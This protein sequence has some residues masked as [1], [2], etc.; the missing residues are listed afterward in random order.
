MKRCFFH[1]ATRVAIAAFFTFCAI[2]QGRAPEAAAPG[3]ALFVAN[4]AFCH[5]AGARGGSQGG[6]DLVPSPI[7]RNDVDGKQLSTFLKVGRPDK[8]MPAFH[9]TGQQVKALSAFLH[10]VVAASAAGP[11]L[12]SEILVG[13]ASAGKAFFESG[14]GCT[15]CHSIE[16]DLKGIGAKY[17]PLVLQGRLVLPRG[18]GGYPG[19]ETPEQ[20]SIDVTVTMLDGHAQSGLLLFLSDYYV[21]FVDAAGNRHTLPRSGDVP[22]VQVQDP[23]TAHLELQAKLTGQQ[24]HDLTAY[25]ASVK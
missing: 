22:K 25:L 14:G 12:G 11:S 20:P 17:P 23:L 10:S 6:P 15:R 3:Q 8:G 19:F 24:M 5:G 2:G 13:N 18:K 16:R 7:L 9:L 4:C 21:S 1:L